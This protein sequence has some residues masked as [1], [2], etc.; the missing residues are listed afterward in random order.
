MNLVW[1]AGSF[2]EGRPA[3]SHWEDISELQFSSLTSFQFQVM[4]HGWLVSAFAQD[5][6]CS[7]MRDWLVYTLHLLHGIIWI[8]ESREGR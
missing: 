6:L 3:W 8:K 5:S 1:R 4:L 2:E 7:G